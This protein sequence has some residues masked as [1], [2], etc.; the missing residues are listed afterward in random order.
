[1]SDRLKKIKTKLAASE[2]QAGGSE[3]DLKV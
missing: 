3:T 2:R 1:M